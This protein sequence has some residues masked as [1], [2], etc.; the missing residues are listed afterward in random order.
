M[1]TGLEVDWCPGHSAVN[2]HTVHATTA[3]APSTK[4]LL[5]MTSL[6][7]H[8]SAVGRGGCTTALPDSSSSYIFCMSGI[9]WA[10][11]LV[12]GRAHLKLKLAQMT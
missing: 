1:V 11:Q 3:A 6:V 7:A 2:P 10:H 12:A 4:G 9:R 8:S 5:R